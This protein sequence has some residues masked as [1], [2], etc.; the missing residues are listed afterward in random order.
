MPNKRLGLCIAA[1]VATILGVL[2]GSLLLIG[3]GV[4]AAVAAC[5]GISDTY[6]LPRMAGHYGLLI[7]ALLLSVIVCIL[8]FQDFK[9]P[10][11]NLLWSIAM[12]MYIFGALRFD[13]TTSTKATTA[14][15]EKRYLD[16]HVLVIPVILIAFALR[17]H[18]LETLPPLHGD[19]GEMGLAA[20]RVLANEAPPL[21]AV[22]WMDHPA[23]FHYIQAVP[24]AIFGRTGL[25]LR[26]LSV[27]AGVLCIPLIYILGWRGWGGVA[28]LAA[29]WLMTVSHLHI[30][31]SRIG[32]NNMESTLAMLLFLTLMTR[33]RP[34]RLTPLAVSGLVVGLAQYLYYGA[35]IIP[36]IAVVLLLVI[37]KKKMINFKQIAAFGLA[38]LIAYAPLAAF[39][40]THP[41]A[42][43][44]RSRG[45]FLLNEQNVKHTLQSNE[46]SVPRDL[47]PLLKEQAKRNLNFFVKGGDRS[48]FYSAAVPAF[49]LVTSILFWLGLGLVLTRL[50]RF[51]EIAVLSW[52]GLGLLFGGILTN[53]APN[54]PRLLIVIPVVFLLGG[55]LLQQ[56]GRLL[57]LYPQTF[58]LLALG[59]ILALTGFFNL[60]IYFDDFAS[61]LPPNNFTSDSIAREII[62]AEPTDN[63][64]LMGLPHLS[65][66]YGTIHFLAGDN[67]VDLADPADIPAL[68]GQ[69]LLV[70]A[71]PDQVDNLEAIEQR[72]PGG[73]LQS[74]VNQRND[75]MYS[76]Y[77]V[78]ARP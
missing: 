27:V 63:V 52:L 37:W 13:R 48:A 73:R 67:A 16:K 24:V 23:F 56:A 40:A 38:V 5:Y 62:T 25:A 64:F 49:D 18:N 45:V 74:R 46:A 30:H 51:Q 41:D 7:G 28:G 75:P 20:L 50:R 44:S 76:I 47:L 29:A 72:I 19:E 39:Y 68:N 65:V 77:H 53:D 9:N 34:N 66:K 17:F 33:I 26:I 60:K 61:N 58:K 1:I 78:P 12:I 14:R 11:I 6:T 35:R 36:L 10:V 8:V 2:T 42:F 43:V 22:G 57:S 54:A 55:I 21:T 31:F 70:I 69:G 15:Y 4:A 71:L 59:L 32:L 3:G